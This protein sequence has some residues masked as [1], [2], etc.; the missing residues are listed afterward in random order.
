[1]GAPKWWLMPQREKSKR[2]ETSCGALLKPSAQVRP[3][4]WGKRSGPGTRLGQPES[5][6]REDNLRAT[7]A[8]SL[9]TVALPQGPDPGCYQPCRREAKALFQAKDEASHSF[10]LDFANCVSLLKLISEYSLLEVWKGLYYKL[11]I[12][13]EDP[14]NK[15]Y[16]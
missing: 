2:G 7:Q 4:G 10:C 14:K 3:L 5:R 16:L 1:M 6:G 9:G 13:M 11:K 15:T 12:N 8:E